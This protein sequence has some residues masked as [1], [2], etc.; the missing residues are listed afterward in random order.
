MRQALFFFIVGFVLG[1]ALSTSA[2]A[3]ACLVMVVF[4]LL[5]VGGVQFLTDMDNRLRR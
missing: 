2:E 4:V 5:F 3:T 1:M